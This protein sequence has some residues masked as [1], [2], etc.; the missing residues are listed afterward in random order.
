MTAGSLTDRDSYSRAFH[1]EV[2]TMLDIV[3]VVASIAFFAI[4]LGYVVACERW[5]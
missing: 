5:I 2:E 3:F 4:A 1:P